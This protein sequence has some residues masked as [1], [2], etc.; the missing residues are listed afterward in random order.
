MTSARLF[1][2]EAAELIPICKKLA[3]FYSL[4]K[5]LDFYLSEKDYCI[6][7]ALHYYLLILSL[8][9]IVNFRIYAYFGGRKKKMN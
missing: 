8:E 6:F 1:M 7:L 2:V 4:I 9:F 3:W 5:D